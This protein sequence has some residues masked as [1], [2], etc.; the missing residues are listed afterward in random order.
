[1]NSYFFHKLKF[2]QKYDDFRKTSKFVFMIKTTEQDSNYRHLEKMS[3]QELL[4]N[5]NQEDQTVP[6]AVQKVIPQ[7]EALVDDISDKLLAGGRLFYIGAGTSGRL[8][9][10]DASECPPTFGVPHELVIGLI[11]GGDQA[12]R[13]AVEFAEDSPAQAWD[14]LKAH[15]VSGKDVVV[16]VAASGT[17]PYVIGGLKAC[18]EAGI[19]TGCI[20]CNAA[21]PLE[22]VAD[23]PIV[24]VVGP[25]FV[26]GSTR[27]KSGTAQKLILNMIS[28]AVM[29]KIGRVEDNKMVNMQL[30]NH[31]LVARGVKMIMVATGVSETIARE[32]L[33]ATNSVKKAIDQLNQK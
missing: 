25:E 9:I 10:L 32:M 16:G 27:M 21:S 11:A 18:Q 7:I 29:I 3:T 5:M 17:T 14:D 22:A 4:T 2:A 15:N 19:T 20:T 30:S 8:G 1:M 26:T 31:K 12:I 6:Q 33:L 13:K 23:Y 24:C 28:T